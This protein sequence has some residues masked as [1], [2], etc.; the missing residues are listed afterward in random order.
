MYS[1][2]LHEPKL[3]KKNQKLKIQDHFE[4]KYYF[5]FIN[6]Q[7]KEC[8]LLFF[9][10]NLQVDAKANILKNISA[11]ARYDRLKIVAA[12]LHGAQNFS[13]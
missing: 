3:R 5:S 7:Q 11:K 6:K 9:L 13:F 1:Y 2:A 10:M 4:K 8:I 12:T